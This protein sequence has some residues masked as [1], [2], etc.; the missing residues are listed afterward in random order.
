M[1]GRSSFAFLVVAAMLVAG[2]S[3]SGR[4]TPKEA[5]FVVTSTLP[6]V[7]E[8]GSGEAARPAPEPPKA[9]TRGHLA[10]FVVSDTLRP[11]AGAH[12]RL[13]GMDLTQKSERDGAFGFVDL[14][15][16][17]YF[18]TVNATGYYPAEAEIVVKA[19][20]FVRVKVV[21]TPIPPPTPYHRTETFR[22][23]A[24]L[25]SGP[26]YNSC[27]VCNGCSASVYPERV[28]E[29]LVLEAYTDSPDV[30]FRLYL[31]GT[32]SSYLV[33]GD[34]PNPMRI[35]VPAEKLATAGGEYRLRVYPESLVPQMNVKF[36]FYAT[37]FY[38]E[39]APPGWAILNGDT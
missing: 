34:F 28:P 1:S 7:T 9:G 6:D 38:H 12:V 3:G 21:L 11:V 5:D 29:T 22:G 13:P 36:D 14:R 25:S 33:S 26:L 23:F 30:G 17:P 4:T 32:G 31:Q 39:P 35:E 15:P 19:D 18:L 37:M 27:F 8:I 20:E 24:D 10:G 2:C 16:G